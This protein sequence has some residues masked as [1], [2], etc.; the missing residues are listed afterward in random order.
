MWKRITETQRQFGIWIV[1]W[2]DSP[3]HLHAANY[4]SDLSTWVSVDDEPVTQHLYHKAPTH[5]LD[6]DSLKWEE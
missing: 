4:D 6:L 5:Y 1:G 3:N 2:R